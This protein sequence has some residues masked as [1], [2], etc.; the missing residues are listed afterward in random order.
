MTAVHHEQKKAL[1]TGLFGIYIKR[2]NGPG[3]F[4]KQIELTQSLNTTK[5]GFS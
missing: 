1:T 5:T 3:C 2:D 4:T